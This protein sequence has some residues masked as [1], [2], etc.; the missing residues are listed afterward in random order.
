MTDLT[1]YY[2]YFTGQY[3]ALSLEFAGDRIPPSQMVKV[4]TFISVVLHVLFSL[5]N[6]LFNMVTK[7]FQNLLEL[8]HMCLEFEYWV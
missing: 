2:F 3:Y 7:T 8:V 4:R 5:S 1:T 6:F